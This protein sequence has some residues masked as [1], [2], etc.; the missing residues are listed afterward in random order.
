MVE[1]PVIVALDFADAESALGF[2]ARLDPSLCRLKVGFEL[3]VAAGPALVEKL[4]GR[5]FEVF[6]D[7]KFH[8]IPNTVAAACKAAAGL[9]VWMMNLHAGGGATMMSAAR[10]ALE[11]VNGRRPLLIA[12]TV[13]TS[14][15]ASDLRAA[16]YECDPQTLVRRR[17][18]QARDAG[19]GGIVCSAAEAAM[20]RAVVGDDMAVV[21]PGIRPSGADHGDQ[22]RVVS[23][24]DALRSGSSHLVVARPIV[25]APDPLAAARAIL[26]E[27]E[28][29]LQ[30]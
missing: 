19:M 3:F 5:G 22:K 29:A 28:G 13:L 24:T 7:L 15:D 4:I 2:A 8:D 27:M 10:E 25:K 20:V 14:M 17:A 12:V 18:A 16:G 23:P 9:G 6:L 1:R 30:A 21:T 11:T 26:E